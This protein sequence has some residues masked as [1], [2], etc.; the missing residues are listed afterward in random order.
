MGLLDNAI[1]RRTAALS[2]IGKAALNLQYPDEFEYYMIALELM[3][4]N[5]CTLQY[6]IFPI[7]P[8]SILERFPTITNTKKTL[9]GVSVVSSSQFIPT[10][11][12]LSGN[13]GRK[14]K[15]VLGGDGATAVDL[16]HS[17]NASGTPT[18]NSVLNSA[19]NFFD[20]KV[21]T[22]YGCIKILQNMIEASKQI[23]SSGPRYLALYNLVSNN[24]Y[25]VKPGDLS[26]SM[27]MESNMIWNYS[28][29][30]KSIAPLSNLISQAD[31]QSTL[32]QLVVTDLLQKETNTLLNSLTTITSNIQNK[33]QR[34]F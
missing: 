18:V 4:S 7:M 9:G 11:I 21:K 10:D 2:T 13:F 23:D 25:F 28:L 14:F 34:I 20:T 27:S 15:V 33:V 17:F 3:D 19:N 31:L 5:F 16:V 12:T 30:L 22:G 26:I 32:K 1:A 24:N 8:T 29:P 6:F